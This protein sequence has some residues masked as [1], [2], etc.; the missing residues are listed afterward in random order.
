M[1]SNPQLKKLL[2]AINFPARGLKETNE[3]RNLLHAAQEYLKQFETTDDKRAL[4]NQT[5]LCVVD[6]MKFIE[7][8]KGRIE[9]SEKVDWTSVYDT[10]L[11]NNFKIRKDSE[12]SY[13]KNQRLKSYR[14]R[15]HA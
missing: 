3:E 6:L 2:A 8:Q 5:G 11:A 10:R 9:K 13:L 14:G 1:V 7:L 12:K 4:A 15:I